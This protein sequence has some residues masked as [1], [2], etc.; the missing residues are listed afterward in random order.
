MEDKKIS[1]QLKEIQETQE[2]HSKLYSSNYSDFVKNYVR[3]EHLDRF[4]DKLDTVNSKIDKFIEK[5]DLK[6]SKNTEF[7]NRMTGAM[8][9]I[10]AVGLGNIALFLFYLTKIFNNNI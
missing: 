10:A 9:F 4:V 1:Q 3:N 5:A 7:R 8:I 6:I 2:N